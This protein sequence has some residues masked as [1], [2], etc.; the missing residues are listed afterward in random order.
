MRD[1]AAQRLGGVERGVSR[2]RAHPVGDDGV[3]LGGDRRV[4]ALDAGPV[5][6]MVDEVVP[7]HQLAQRGPVALGEDVDPEVAVGAR[8]DPERVAVAQPGHLGAGEAV[9]DGRQGEHVEQR[10][11]GADLDE[12]A[13]AVA[14]AGR[15]GEQDAERA[16]GA[17]RAAPARWPGH[18][19]RTTVGSDG[20]E[21]AGGQLGQLGR[22]PAGAWAVEPVGRER[23]DDEPGMG[24][25]QVV[26]A[27]PHIRRRAEGTVVEHDIGVGHQPL[28]Q[29]C[30]RRRGDVEGQRALLS[31]EEPVAAGATGFVRPVRGLDLDDVGAEHRQQPPAV[32]ARDPARQLQHGRAI[33]RWSTTHRRPTL[34]GACPT[35]VGR[36]DSGVRR[37]APWRR[38]SRG[39]CPRR[40]RR[41][42]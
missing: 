21:A 15:E 7:S 23:G 26:V 3:E 34:G 16:D 42:G 41:G 14:A 32:G 8:V 4:G 30:A 40:R 12:L 5:A 11:L 10:L 9:D 19:R 6:R 39:R 24:G 33:E 29:R 37:G 2:L 13:R 27:G 35:V 25:E 31:V 17:D 22:Q 1:R 28:E 20:Q 38:R 36:G 18:D